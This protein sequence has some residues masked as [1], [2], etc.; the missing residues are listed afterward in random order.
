MT[1]RRNYLSSTGGFADGFMGG[2]G[3]VTDADTKRQQL[4]YDR[5]SDAARAAADE[6]RFQASEAAAERRFGLQQK[7]ADRQFKLDSDLLESRRESNRL[8][9]GIDATRAETALLQQQASI[10]EIEAAEAEQAQAEYLTRATNAY[11]RINTMLQAPV[12]TYSY[13]QIIAAIDDTE[14]GSL[15]IRQLL[16]ADFQAD[17]AGMTSEI[18]KG[19]EA[20]ELDLNHRAILDGLTAMFDNK[21]GRL[22]GRTVDG[23]FNNAPDQFKTG[24]WEV[25]DRFVTNVKQNEN[26]PAMLSATVSVRV[27]NKKTGE[28]AY[29]D[30]PLTENRG[31]GTAPVGISIKDALDGIAGTSMLLQQIENFRPDIERGLIQ[32]KFGNDNLKFESA[33]DAEIQRS[34]EKASNDGGDVRSIIPT[35]LNSSLTMDD[36]RNLARS[37]VLGTGRGEKLDFRGDRLRV[38]SEAKDQLDPMLARALFEDAD[39][40][41]KRIA[42]SNSEILRM[43]AMDNEA[44]VE[45]YIATLAKAKGGFMQGYDGSAR[46]QTAGSS[47]GAKIVRP[48]SAGSSLGNPRFFSS[49]RK[50]G[51]TLE[52]IG[53]YV[54]EVGQEA[55]RIR[56][57]QN[58]SR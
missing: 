41:V 54:D 48:D 4:E 12:G 22:I 13:D 37:K 15:D 16:G 14:G 35:K 30:A 26:D 31:A 8:Q 27:V 51:N 47:S 19:L 55:E 3:M 11:G 10:A 20:G 40:K 21:R 36:H 9:A 29:Y 17:I 45:E 46:G 18:R 34:L 56:Q 49:S 39:G 23:T 24:E 53:D 44:A 5:E 43:N 28:S 33:V 50:T 52:Q 57:A 6:R 38:I 7:S 42:F 58:T 32:Q 2:F 1:T 25:A